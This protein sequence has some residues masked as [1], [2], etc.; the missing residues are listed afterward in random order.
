MAQH[1]GAAPIEFSGR[2][3]P[4]LENNNLNPLV[5]RSR[6]LCGGVSKDALRDSLVLADEAVP[7]AQYVKTTSAGNSL[8]VAFA[9][10]T[11]F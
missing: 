3:D 4:S 9:L 7:S 10:A 8:I 1:I 5:L 11:N 2:T 6:R